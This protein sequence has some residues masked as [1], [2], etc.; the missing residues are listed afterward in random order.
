M[1]SDLILLYYLFISVASMGIPPLSLSLSLSLSSLRACT[2]M[3]NENFKRPRQNVST[4]L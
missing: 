4:E 1:R 3:Q 2:V